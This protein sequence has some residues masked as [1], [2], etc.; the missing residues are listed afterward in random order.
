MSG[1]Y[2]PET[3]HCDGALVVVR[4]FNAFAHRDC[5]DLSYDREGRD[6]VALGCEVQAIDYESGE[7]VSCDLTPEQHE[8]LFDAG[9]QQ[10]LD[11]IERWNWD[12]AMDRAS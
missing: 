2:A 3:Q 9:L 1:L 10:A 11:A 7:P 4:V 12:L 6:S 8:R 5:F